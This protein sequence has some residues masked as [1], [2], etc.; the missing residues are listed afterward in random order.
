MKKWVAALLI[1]GLLVSTAAALAQETP[2]TEVPATVYPTTTTT[3]GVTQE[4]VQQTIESD[5]WFGII[6]VPQT[7]HGI[8]SFILDRS[9]V[10]LGFTDLTVRVALLVVLGIIT[11]VFMMTHLGFGIILLILWLLMNFL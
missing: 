6:P 8:L 10:N 7:S 1:I 4:Q 3:A 11:L 9:L 5:K 2:T